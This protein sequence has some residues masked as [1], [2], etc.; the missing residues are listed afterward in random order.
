MES[1]AHPFAKKSCVSLQETENEKA[2][3]LLRNV[4]PTEQLVPARRAFLFG[5]FVATA[6]TQH[7][8]EKKP[9]KGEC[10]H[11]PSQSRV[12]AR[13]P[14]REPS[15]LTAPGRGVGTAPL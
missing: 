14:W 2:L 3:I 11:G 12:D 10:A 9:G 1:I 5:Q 13:S 15:P 8:D 6:V 7:T 4:N